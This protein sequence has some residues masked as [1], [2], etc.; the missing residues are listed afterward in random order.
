MGK[1]VEQPIKT[2]FHGVSRQPDAVR[3]PGQIED[4]ENLVFSVETGGFSKR[5]GSRH[6][7]SLSGFTPLSNIQVHVIDRDTNERYVVIKSGSSLK[8]YD[9]DGNEKVV[10]IPSP[11]VTG[12]LEGNDFSFVSVADYTFILNKQKIVTM[13]ADVAPAQQNWAVVQVAG[14]REGTFGITI[15]GTY[16]ATA[17]TATA[18]TAGIAVYLRDA[19]N[20]VLGGTFTVSA[21][22]G[23]VF[24]QKNDGADFLITT[25]DP[26]SDTGLKLT[27][28]TVR[29]STDLPLRA[30]DGMI[31]KVGNES[32]GE[33]WV[34]FTAINGSSGMWR[35]T[36]KPGEKIKFNAA[37]MPHVLVREADGTFTVKA[38]TWDDKKVG[39]EKTV[40][41]PD[42]VG[43]TIN[44]IVFHRNRLA[45]LADETVFFSQ[46]GDYFNM[47]PDKA[48][49]V[50]DS[51][52]FGMSSQANRV[53]ILR[54]G[55]PFRRSLFATAD[56]AQFEVSG[57]LLSPKKAVIDLATSYNVSRQARPCQMGD[58]L[59]LGAENGDEAVVLEY[60]YD[61][62]SMSNFASDITKHV[63]GYIPSPLVAITGDPVSGTLFALSDKDRSTI[64]TFTTY[65]SGDERAQSAWG[66][67]TVTDGYIHS[68]AY[69]AGFLVLAVS[70]DDGVFLEKI[71]VGLQ[72]YDAFPFAPR[73]DRECRAVGSYDAAT[74]LTT[75]T[76]PYPAA[77]VRAFSSE[78]LTAPACRGVSFPVTTDGTKVTARGDWTGGEVAFGFEFNASATLS[79]IFARENDASILNGRLQLR[80]IT[81]SYDKTG[82][83]EVEITPSVREPVVKAFTGRILGSAENKVNSHPLESGSFKALVGSRADTVKIRV[84]NNTFLPFTVTSAAWVG[85]FNEVSRQG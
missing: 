65:W 27:K 78:D 62:S 16:C 44:D 72:D 63:R 76:L 45:L 77:G 47:W 32:P 29:K 73:L 2:L 58:S 56:N 36:V 10:N 42:F 69:V 84:V 81:F 1:L 22:S 17:A 18:D 64:Y 33:Y 9:L 60:S 80:A 13:A 40:P 20:A 83:M 19:I 28:G 31:V 24:I 39:D 66:K 37:T 11:A 68:I 34:K 53:T 41:N 14:A 8:V 54:Y 4:A 3:L 30:M 5:Y 74:R 59:Y 75:W 79:K 23:F 50:L 52:P 49:E 55:V 6:I 12:Y 61:D 48:T 67:W 26:I 21:E 51:D 7:A 71:T 85:F 35:E 70:R 38:A 43:T 46:A 15:N 57:E 25:N 82:Y